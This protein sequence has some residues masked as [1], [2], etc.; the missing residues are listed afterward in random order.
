MGIAHGYRRERDRLSVQ[1]QPVAQ[2]FFR[3]QFRPERDAWRCEAGYIHLD[4]HPAV[5]EQARVHASADRIEREA[6][7]LR[8]RAIPDKPGH[9]ATAVAALLGFAAV[10]VVYEKVE[11]CVGNRGRQHRQQLVET[12]AGAAIAPGPDAFAVQVGS[13]RDQVNH[14]EVVAEAMH[15]REPKVHRVIIV[16]YRAGT[17]RLVGAAI[18]CPK[19]CPMDQGV[20]FGNSGRGMLDAMVRNPPGRQG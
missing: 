7:F 11:V 9:A 8:Q 15:L 5:L 14:H 3:G 18:P 13:L 6:P 19:G 1:R 4:P 16:A 17:P 10:A 20:P 12:D 2:S